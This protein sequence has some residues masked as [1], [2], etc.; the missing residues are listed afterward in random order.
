MKISVMDRDLLMQ[1]WLSLSQAVAAIERTMLTADGPKDLWLACRTAR[2]HAIAAKHIVNSRLAEVQRVP[3]KA[4]SDI[5]KEFS[6]DT[7]DDY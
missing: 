7:T 3:P 5:A 1:Q 2:E 6:N 4:I